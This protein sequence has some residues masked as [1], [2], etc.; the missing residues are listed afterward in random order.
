M[1]SAAPTEAL[2]RRLEGLLESRTRANERFFAA[3]AGRIARLCHA[4][5]SGS[6]AAA[7]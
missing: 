1:R 7:G 4:W 5:P 3:E 6:A 2:G